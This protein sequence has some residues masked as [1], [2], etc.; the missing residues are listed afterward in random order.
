MAKCA[1][2][3]ESMNRILAI[4]LAAVICSMPLPASAEPVSGIAAL[5]NDEPITTYD[6]EKERE[7]LEKGLDGKTSLDEAAKAQLQQVALNSLINKKLIEQKIRELDIKVTDEE[8]RQSIEDVK[9]T[10]NLTQENLKEALEA[11]GITFDEY[12]AQIKEQL[13]RLRLI[14]MEVRSKIQISEK[15]MQEYYASNSDKF[16][17]DEAFHA[18]Q[19]FLPVSPKATEEEQK[20]ATASAEKI[21]A[22]AKGGA[23]FAGLAKKYSK[24]PSA[25]EGGDLGFLKKGEILPEFEEVLVNLKPGEISGLIRTQAGIHIL[26]LEELRQGKRQTFEAVKPELEDLLYKKRSEERFSQ[27]IDE[28]RK[29]AAVEIK[30]A[31]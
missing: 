21:L 5:V 25:A 7:S 12:K 14:S 1:D 10:N 15:E 28:L 22:E 24:D 3:K 23:D 29:N 31:K 11:R 9:R 2:R 26:K 17:V 13:E 20:R 18:R 30:P 4:L 16:Q 27:W 19:I 8:V 6:V